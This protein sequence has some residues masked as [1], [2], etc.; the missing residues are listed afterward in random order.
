MYSHG[1]AKHL[2]VLMAEHKSIKAVSVMKTE[3]KIEA[4]N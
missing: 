1:I 4:L 2:Y 3:E